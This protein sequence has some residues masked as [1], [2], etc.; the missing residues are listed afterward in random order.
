MRDKM[1]INYDHPGKWKKD[2][3][4][5]IEYYNSWFLE[6]AP[7]TFISTR[8]SCK[9]EINNYFKKSSYLCDISPN[10][11]CEHP[12]SLNMFRMITAPPIARDRLVGLADVPRSF[13]ENMESSDR[14][15]PKMQLNK[16]K[17]NL[18]SICS[19]LNTLLDADLFPWVLESREPSE[20]ELDRGLVVVADRLSGA[21]S[22][23]LIRNEQEKRQLSSIR[24][25]LEDNGYTFIENGS[26]IKYN[27]MEP[28]TFAFHLDVP[29][30]QEDG[31]EVNVPVDV[32]ILPKDREV[33]DLPILIEAKSAG[34]EVNTNKRRKEEANKLVNLRR[35]FGDGVEYILFLCGYFNAGYL[36]YAAAD[37]MDWIWEHNINEL[38]GLGL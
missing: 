26:G 35:Q 6:F 9:A 22:N 25:W 27:A 38:E 14:L 12:K 20:R 31:K 21:I 28:G 3:G 23:P 5:S 33:G 34:D 24:N 2:I 19:V 15:P 8:A 17:K 13:I 10:F 16:V 4:L 37:K 18:Q 7:P 1:G 32:A 36:G 11:F 30:L 29:G